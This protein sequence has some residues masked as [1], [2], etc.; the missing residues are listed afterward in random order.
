MIVFHHCRVPN[1]QQ[2]QV[3]FSP[4][5]R[6]RDRDR[7]ERGRIVALPSKSNKFNHLSCLLPAAAGH[8][9]GLEWRGRRRPA[10]SSPGFGHGTC[11]PRAE[12]AGLKGSGIKGDG[13]EQAEQTGFL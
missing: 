9:L 6:A 1:A 4:A 10:R 13:R 12:L 8:R 3:E 5:T 11:G 2:S 7:G